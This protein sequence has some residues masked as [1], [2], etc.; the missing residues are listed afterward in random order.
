MIKLESKNINRIL[1]LIFL[2]SYIIF[3]Y[4]FSN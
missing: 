3:N 2:L 4:F 1:V